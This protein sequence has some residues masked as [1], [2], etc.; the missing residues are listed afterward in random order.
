VTESNHNLDS[1]LGNKKVGDNG[2][3]LREN[4]TTHVSSNLGTKGNSVS[5]QE[6]GGKILSDE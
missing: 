3:P 4:Q 5:I 1:S 2:R 6:F